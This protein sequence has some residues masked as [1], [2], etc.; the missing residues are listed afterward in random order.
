MLYTNPNCIYIYDLQGNFIKSINIDTTYEVES[1]S[2]DWNGNFY[3]TVNVHGETKNSH[4]IYY[5]NIFKYITSES[6]E[7]LIN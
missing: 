2:Y 1:L 4:K 5:I 7:L 6:V 3:L